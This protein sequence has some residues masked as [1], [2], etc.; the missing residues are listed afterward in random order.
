MNGRMDTVLPTFDQDN[1]PT[2]SSPSS[3]VVAAVSASVSYSRSF[4]FMVLGTTRPSRQPRWICCRCLRCCCCCVI[5][6]I[7]RLRLR[8][9]NAFFIRGVGVGVTSI[10]VSLLCQIFPIHSI[11]LIFSS[12]LFWCRCLNCHHWCSFV[13]QRLP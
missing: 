13:R 9:L 6:A 11:Q 12:H 1:H 7:T 3:S 5:I 10:L 8:P 2:S 4:M